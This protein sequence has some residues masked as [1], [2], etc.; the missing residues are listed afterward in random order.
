[1]FQQIGIVLRT[2]YFQRVNSMEFEEFKVGNK[3]IKFF[4]KEHVYKMGK[5]VLNS[6]SK[7]VE[8][9]DKPAIPIS[10][11][12]ASLKH[13][14]DNYGSKDI[15][16]VIKDSR[17]AFQKKTKK[18]MS[19]GTNAHQ[20][21]ELVIRVAMG[22]VAKS[23]LKKVEYLCDEEE[24]CVKAFR[25]FFKKEKPVFIESEKRL[26][27]KHTKSKTDF[28][29]TLDAIARKTKHSKK[30]ILYDWK[31]SS[32]YYES[33]GVQVSAYMMSALKMGYNITEVQ[34][35][36]FF[37]EDTED[38]ETGK[39]YKAGDYMIKKFTVEEMKEIF[40]K[41]FIPLLTYTINKKQIN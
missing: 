8:L 33:M 17:W 16:M 34:I 21:I 23:E 11:V 25:K 31:T 37:K 12:D 14:T 18:A 29:G 13:I 38:R 2:W 6:P 5:R 40:E 32:G 10:A 30:L 22:E 27:Y 26:Y 1:M 19:I 39:K 3:T 20:I 36:V 28:C 24:I 9:M 35:V 7:V 41:L 15:E 4:P